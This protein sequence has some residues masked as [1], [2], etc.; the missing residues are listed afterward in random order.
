MLGLKGLG[1]FSS[2][3]EGNGG[4]CDEDTKTR[5]LSVVR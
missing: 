3:R 5:E 4:G 1:E 2:G